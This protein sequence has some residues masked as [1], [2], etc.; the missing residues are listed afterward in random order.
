VNA[1]ARYRSIVSGRADVTASEG[2]PDVAVAG[3]SVNL[4]QKPS[5]NCRWNQWPW[6][7]SSTRGHRP[8]EES[9]S[10][11]EAFK[12][13]DDDDDDGDDDETSTT[14]RYVYFYFNICLTFFRTLFS[15]NTTR[16]RFWNKFYLINYW[17]LLNWYFKNNFFVRCFSHWHSENVAT[18]KCSE[19][20]QITFARAINTG[21]SWRF[22]LLEPKHL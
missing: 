17:I 9:F 21:V 3:P 1:L 16:I 18:L 8:R 12:D 2:I 11:S 19:I 20:L 15:L 5:R 14:M 22:S 10:T 7:A 4:A 13:N 6:R